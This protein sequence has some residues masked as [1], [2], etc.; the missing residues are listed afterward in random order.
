M[1]RSD[2]L[3]SF[4]PIAEHYDVLMQNVPY[5]MW[6]SYYE[7]LL[8]QLDADPATLLDVCCGTG[9][10]AEMLDAKGYCLTGFDLSEAMVKEAKR[11]AEAGRLE[12]DYHVA[13]V[14]EL[15]LGRRFDGAYSFF[16]SLNYVV[17]PGRLRLGLA[18]VAAHLSPGG[19][20]IF[21]LNTAY[22]FEKKM[23][24]QSESRA[25][26]PIRYKWKGD[27]DPG[28]RV[29]H[30]AMEFE[31]DGVVMH[32]THVQRAHP[33]EEVRAYLAEAGFVEIRSFN[34]YTL[35]PPRKRS[36]RIHIAAC[37]P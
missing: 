29:I 23:F 21:D 17:D 11:K 28:T 30:V 20:F 8:L 12:I 4:G 7:L 33:E 26:A 35:D 9:T 2:Q 22:A 32:E 27:Y 18:R 1:R 37:L 6:V 10:V 14:A 31:R 13:D 5:D 3:A 16:D 15:A 36:D 34:S 24:D 19:T 25:K